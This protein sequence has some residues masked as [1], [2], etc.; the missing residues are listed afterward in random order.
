MKFQ[1]KNQ[2]NQV[3]FCTEDESCIPSNDALDSMSNV[4]MTFYIDGKKISLSSLKSR[5][6]SD[7]KT[8][9]PEVKP[10]KSEDNTTLDS[11]GITSKPSTDAKPVVK[12]VPNPTS[13][14]TGKS[15]SLIPNKTKSDVKS[16]VDSKTTP[17]FPITSRCVICINNGKMYRNQKEAGEDLGI[18][19]SWISWCIT[20][21]KEYK[22]YTFKKAV[23]S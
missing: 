10:D 21:N 1:V 22:G 18:D 12:S 6:L 11:T 17:D 8:A 15:I 20:K 9:K 23:K 16:V 5:K 7:S 13:K 3:M 2:Q 19:P 4:N 14:K